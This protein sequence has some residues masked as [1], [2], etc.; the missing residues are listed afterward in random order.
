MIPLQGVFDWVNGLAEDVKSTV[1]TVVVVVAIV[2]IVVEAVRS[3][4]SVAKIVTAVLVAGFLV[5][6]VLG[7]ETISGWFE[8]EIQ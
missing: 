3:K 8:T 4:L 7:I 6:A 2:F 1:A 5:A